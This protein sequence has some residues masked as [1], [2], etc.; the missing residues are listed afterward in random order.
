MGKQKKNHFLVGSWVNDFDMYAQ[1]A[2]TFNIQGRTQ[3]G[4]RAGFACTII[5]FIFVLGFAVTKTMQLLNHSNSII[6]FLEEPTYYISEDTSLD[7]KTFD[8]HFAFTVQDVSDG[9]H[10]PKNDPG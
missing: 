2:P 10:I 1:T 4:T 7:V 3:V 9:K 5:T 8:F 6:M